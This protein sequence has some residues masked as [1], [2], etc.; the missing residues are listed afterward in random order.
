MEN[1]LHN[2]ISIRQY[3]TISNNIG[4]DN[5]HQ[6]LMRHY[7]YQTIFEYFWRYLAIFINIGTYLTIFIHTILYLEAPKQYINSYGNSSM[8]LLFWN[9]WFDE[10]WMW[11]EQELEEVSLLK[12]LQSTLFGYSHLCLEM[13][14]SMQKLKNWSH[15]SWLTKWTETAYILQRLFLS[16]FQQFLDIFSVKKDWIYCLVDLSRHRFREPKWVLWKICLTYRGV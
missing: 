8:I 14:N 5:I 3:Y 1:N 9:F 6:I 7:M 10:L 13:P 12:I 2:N 4:T 11:Y 16:Y 15:S